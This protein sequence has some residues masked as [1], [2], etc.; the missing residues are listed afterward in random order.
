M[1]TVKFTWHK[2]EANL[3]FAGNP[4][5]KRAV[6]QAAERSGSLVTARYALEE[7]RDVMVVPGAISDPLFAGSNALIKQGAYLVTSVED[8][9]EILPSLKKFPSAEAPLKAQPVGNRAEPDD[10]AELIQRT[11]GRLGSVHM[12]RLAEQLTGTLTRSQIHTAL[13]TLE[14]AGSLLRLPGNCVTLAP[15]V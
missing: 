4:E 11:L 2:A 7:G 3:A 1:V 9:L 15:R 6:I 5:D 10:A 12:D 14:L 13:M 8:V